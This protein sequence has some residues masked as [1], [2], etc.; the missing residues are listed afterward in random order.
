MVTTER[1]LDV[2]KTIDATLKRCITTKAKS[3]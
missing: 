1:V 2:I 3:R